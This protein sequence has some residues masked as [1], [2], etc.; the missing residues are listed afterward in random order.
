MLILPALLLGALLAP[1]S[2]AAAG[3]A[4]QERLNADRKVVYKFTNGDRT[5]GFGQVVVQATSRDR[6]RYCVKVQYGGRR[7]LVSNG[8]STDKRVN[9]AW[10]QEGARGDSGFSAARPGTFTLQ[11]RDKKR[12]NLNYA[13]KTGGR[14][15]RTITIS[16]FNL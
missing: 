1:L 8:V 3:N 13:I 16:R 7:P 12:E 5:L 14:V 15:Y 4:C 6:H 11:V 9:G 10:V 2:A